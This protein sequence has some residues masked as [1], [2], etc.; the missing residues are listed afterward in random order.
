MLETSGTEVVP[1]TGSPIGIFF[2][3]LAQCFTASQFV[4]EVFES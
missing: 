3:I 2:V 4:I 1:A